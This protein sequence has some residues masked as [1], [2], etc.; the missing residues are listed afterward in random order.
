MTN[1]C[2]FPFDEDFKA[3]IKKE[4]ESPEVQALKDC[5]TKDHF[6]KV[7]ENLRMYLKK[8][9]PTY[10]KIK[11]SDMF[12][13]VIALIYPYL[14]SCTTWKD[15]KFRCPNEEKDNAFKWT[16]NSSFIN[17]KSTCVCGHIITVCNSFIVYH[18][19]SPLRI[20]V[21]CCCIEKNEIVEDF[22]PV[23]KQ[24]KIRIEEDIQHRIY[25]THQEQIDTWKNYNDKLLHM[26]RTRT[27]ASCSFCR[28]NVKVPYK[29]CWGCREA[30]FD[31]CECGKSKPKQYPK[32]YTCK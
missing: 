27:N 16:S 21:G 30:N 12:A 11:F 18:K 2:S 13:F 14:D 1:R 31:T 17:M 28:K 8:K 29:I 20:V 4:R 15:L 24:R 22:G 32:C 9:Y 3:M 26:H 6:E 7:Q 23:K 19:D 25:L 10:F 5:E